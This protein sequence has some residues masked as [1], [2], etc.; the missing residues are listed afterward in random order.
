MK[1]TVV[2]YS[3]FQSKKSGDFFANV[4][5]T[6]SGDGTKLIGDRAFSVFVSSS[7]SL[8]EKLNPE[9]IGQS[10]DVF[11]V[12]GKDGGEYRVGE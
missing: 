11:Y 4:F 5:C 1:A 9:F 3:K 10:I 12:G 6:S 8:L 2:G 7:Y